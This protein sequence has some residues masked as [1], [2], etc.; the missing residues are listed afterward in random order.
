VAFQ[1]RMN[2]DI[3]KVRALTNCFCL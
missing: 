3:K 1:W 2:Q